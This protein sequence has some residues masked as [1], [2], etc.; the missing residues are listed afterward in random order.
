MLSRAL[1]ELLV[2]KG[3][4]LIEVEGVGF[5][6]GGIELWGVQQVVF[7][8][9]VDASWSIPLNSS[10]LFE[11]IKVILEL[12][13]KDI[14]TLRIRD[15]TLFAVFLVQLI[16]HRQRNILFRL[17]EEVV[18][19][20]KVVEHIRPEHHVLR[21]IGVV[22][23]LTKTPINPKTVISDFPKLITDLSHQRLILVSPHCFAGWGDINQPPDDS[24]L[25][26]SD[27]NWLVSTDEKERV[28]S[29]RISFNALLIDKNGLV[30]DDAVEEPVRLDS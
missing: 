7:E 3:F 5:F 28:D 18:L 4:F 16:R 6:W 30:C 12:L 26:V 2:E 24:R 9:R 23:V 25:R 21:L 14:S 20:N 22:V 13:S 10:P 17:E 1:H 19:L 27:L 29:L 8:S 11:I 15:I